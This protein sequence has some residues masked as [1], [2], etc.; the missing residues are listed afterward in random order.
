MSLLAALLPSGR[1]VTA[2]TIHPSNGYLA[3]VL[4]ERWDDGTNAFAPWAGA[5]VA[6]SFALD[7]A[8]VTPIAALQDIPLV[9]LGTDHPGVYAEVIPGPTMDALNPFVGQTIFQ[10]VRNA[11]GDLLVATPLVVRYPRYAQ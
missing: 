9:E 3:R 11:S 1:P 8:G 5:S 6:C 4:L 2:K 7:A 10:I